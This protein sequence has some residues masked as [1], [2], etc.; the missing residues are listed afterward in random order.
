MVVGGL[1]ARMITLLAGPGT[2]LVGAT[3]MLSEDEAHH[4]KVRRGGPGERVRLADG[5]GTIALGTV[6]LQGG[7]FTATLDQVES[8]SPG[9]TTRLAVGAG[10]KDR[11]AQ[12][13]E[14]AAEL[15]ATEI[16][17]I[18]AER[19][20]S[21]AGRLR[22]GGGVPRLERRALEAIKQS[23]AAWAPRVLEPVRLVEFAATPPN[24]ARWLAEARGGLVPPLGATEALTIAVGPEGGFTEEERAALVGAGFVPV[25]LGPFILRFETAAIAALTSAWLARQRDRHG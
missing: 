13:I 4:L 2:L 21:V 19:T 15:G 5:Q 3:V 20:A 18:E 8:V 1:S 11:F 6:G 14:K 17:P 25:R 10:E 16:I 9:P 23:G 12:V 22:G 24:G 7:H